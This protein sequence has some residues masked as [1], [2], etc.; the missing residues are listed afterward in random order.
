MPGPVVTEGERVTFRVPEREDATFRQLATTD[1]RIRHLLGI[2]RHRSETEAEGLVEAMEEG[3][4]RLAYVVC[5][6]DEDAPRGQPDEGDTTPIGLVHVYAVDTERG[7][8]A[9]WLLPEYHGDGYGREAAELTVDRAFETTSIHSL[10]AGAFAH[11]EASRGLL[12]SLGFTLEYRNREAE[13]TD[14][15]YRDFVEYGLLR[16][17]WAE[18]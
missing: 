8:L 5:L 14:G 18:Q 17:E 11:N 4:D 16:R 3:D 2:G 7:H 10:G 1:P 9:Y 15:A 13:Y 12:E 6:D